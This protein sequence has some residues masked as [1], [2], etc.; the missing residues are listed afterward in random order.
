M[1]ARRLVA[2]RWS[3]WWLWMLPPLMTAWFIAWLLWRA[4]RQVRK[5]AWRWIRCPR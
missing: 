5:D 1:S 2:S 4:A 3:K